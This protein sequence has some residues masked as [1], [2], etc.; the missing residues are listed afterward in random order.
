M[1]SAPEPAR[2]P[3]WGWNGQDE[4]LRPVHTGII[5]IVS[6]KIDVIQKNICLVIFENITKILQLK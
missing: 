2:F 4:N 1:G 5:R 6:D 3:G